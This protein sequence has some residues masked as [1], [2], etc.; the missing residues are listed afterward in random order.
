MKEIWKDVEFTNG[1]VKV[2]NLGNAMCDKD[3]Y[4]K[5]NNIFIPKQPKIKC[6]KIYKMILINRKMFYMH[7]L[8]A[9]AFIP[10]PENK[11]EVNHI[12]FNTLNNRVDNLEW[13]TSKENK[14]HSRVNMSEAKKGEKHPQATI[15]D[16]VALSIKKDR[17]KGL[18]YKQLMEKYNL[19]DHT[20]ANVC[21]R[22]Y[23]HLDNKI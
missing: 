7:R 22:Y 8:V 10:N 15:T 12:D 16:N 20:I 18:K 5:I 1:I 9:L 14:Q 13:V 2:S 19:P 4:Y 21:T 6:N 23:K 17:K 11:P 3:A